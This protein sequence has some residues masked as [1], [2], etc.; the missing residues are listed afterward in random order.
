MTCCRSKFYLGVNSVISI[1]LYW[2]LERGYA[3]AFSM[4]A[5]PWSPETLAREEA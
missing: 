1:V 2:Q 3:I 4:T 5:W